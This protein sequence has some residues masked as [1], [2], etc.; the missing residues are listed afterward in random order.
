MKKE[1][2]LAV[3]TLVGFVVG[4]GILG[5]PYVFSQSGFLVGALNVV[6]IGLAVMVLNL[7]IG[8]TSLR[9]KKI[10]QLVGYTGKYLGLNGK[11][12]MLFFLS[13][14]WFGA[15]VAYIVKIGEILSA[16]IRPFIE[17]DPL[18]CSIIFAL[19]GSYLIYKDLLLIEKSEFWL[20]T[21]TIIII[22]SIGILCMPSLNPINLQGFNIQH[23]WLPFG[24][25]LFA[26]G[27][28]GAI[29]EMR[30]ELAKNKKLLK[31]A[32]IIGGLIPI[33]LYLIFP[34]FIVGVTGSATTEE[35]ILG[36]ANILGYKILLLGGFFAI[37][38]M[39]TSFLAVGLAIKDIFKFDMKKTNLNST[40]LACIVPLIV[41]ILVVLLKIDKVFYNVI[42]M[43]GSVFYPFTGIIFVLTFWQAKVKGDR[44][45]EYS[46][47][48]GKLLGILLIILF[49]LGFA[50]K[51]MRTFFV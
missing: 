47:K 32:I 40:M 13:V 10:H 44:K 41:S 2:F 39:S 5:L 23:L 17:I 20:V 18:I 30:E 6:L 51:M 38:A 9:T 48:F 33:A 42:D 21:L 1:L 3:A 49:L 29:P 36:L 16:L 50:N 22:L 12:I 26:F 27:G 11:K 4:A 14:E 19:M 8:E 28:A 15:M 35:G 31:K 37:L 25:T 34:L 24:V 43:C 45:P 7:M 46:L